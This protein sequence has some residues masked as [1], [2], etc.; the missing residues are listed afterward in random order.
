MISLLVTAAE[1]DAEEIGVTGDSYR[2]LFRARRLAV[3][4]RLRLTDGA[5]RARWAEVMAVDRATGT[6]RTAQEAPLHPPAGRVELL[7]AAPEKARASWLVEKATELGVAAVR[8]LATTRTPRDFGDGTVRR[9]ERV[10][11]AALEQSHGSRLPDLSGTHPWNEVAA[12][13]AA[14]DDDARY[15][16]D[17]GEA[18][19][20]GAGLSLDPAGTV[21]LVGPEGGWTEAEREELAGL[22][23]RPVSLGPTTLRTETASLVAAALLLTP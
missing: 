6:V 12:L 7:V 4:D 18:A 5:G 1:L 8:F 9:L 15:L 16:L 11:A 13:V 3:G 20:A 22:G 2:H 17:T 23:A 19:L 10:A 14:A 21:V